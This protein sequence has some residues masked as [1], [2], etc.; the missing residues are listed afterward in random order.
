MSIKF[1]K[2]RRIEDLE[3][4]A[5]KLFDQGYAPLEGGFLEETNPDTV[6]KFIMVMVKKPAAPAPVVGGTTEP[7][8]LRVDIPL[9]TESVKKTKKTTASRSRK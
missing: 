5:N 3:T 8:S 9:E 4:E 1:V 7:Q 2:A 6:E